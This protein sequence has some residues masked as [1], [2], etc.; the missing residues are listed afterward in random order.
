V[1]RAHF[2]AEAGAKELSDKAAELSDGMNEFYDE[3]SELADE[4]YETDNV[5]LTE[6][7]ERA[8]NP[9]IDAAADDVQIS[10]VRRMI[11]TMPCLQIT[12]WA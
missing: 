9:R 7:V 4:M 2:K 8:D 12:I 3:A 1:V 6:F 5:N 11:T 10:L